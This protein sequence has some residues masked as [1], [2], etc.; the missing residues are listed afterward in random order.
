MTLSKRR[1]GIRQREFCFWMPRHLQ[2]DTNTTLVD[3]YRDGN[4]QTWLYV[5]TKWFIRRI[6]EWLLSKSAA[7][8]ASTCGE[9]SSHTA[10]VAGGQ[11]RSQSTLLSDLLVPSW[12]WDKSGAGYLGSGCPSKTKGLADVAWSRSLATSFWC[13]LGSKYATCLS[14]KSSGV[15]LECVT[16]RR[17][18]MKQGPLMLLERCIRISNRSAR[19]IEPFICITALLICMQSAKWLLVQTT[20]NVCNGPQHPT[21]HDSYLTFLMSTRTHASIKMVPWW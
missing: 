2:T 16:W 11:L 4:P 10:S 6:A 17:S 8:A 14:I 1:V 9:N 5:R 21:F 12:T 3:D 19:D 7:A 18:G 13:A 20:Y 15:S